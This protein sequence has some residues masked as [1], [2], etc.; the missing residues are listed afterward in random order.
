MI[1]LHLLNWRDTAAHVR[2]AWRNAGHS[3]TLDRSLHRHYRYCSLLL[4]LHH[5][6]EQELMKLATVVIKLPIH[7]GPDPRSSQ[8]PGSMEHAIPACGRFV[9]YPAGPL[10]GGRLRRRAGPALRRRGWSRSRRLL[11]GFPGC[12]RG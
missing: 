2:Y 4:Q 10:I 8:V 9:A 3:A 7:G 12:R 1:D 5:E 11:R 6:Q